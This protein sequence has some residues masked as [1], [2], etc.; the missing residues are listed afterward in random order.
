MPPVLKRP[1][2]RQ[3]L[4]IFTL[5][6]GSAFLMAAGG[7]NGLILPLRGSAEGF[8]AFSLGMLGTG[9]AIGYVL[10]G[11]GDAGRTCALV[12]RDGRGRRYFGVVV[13]AD[14]SSSRLDSIAGAGR[15]QL[16]RRRYDR[17][18]LDE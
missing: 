11:G 3:I 1:M 6:L 8:S 17:G 13:A 15:I 7:I 16:C 2:F 9:W 12:Q 14:H 4:P 5:I 18:K 10:S